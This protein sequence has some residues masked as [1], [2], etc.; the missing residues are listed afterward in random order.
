MRV[1]FVNPVL[2]KGLGYEPSQSRADLLD[3]AGFDVLRDDGSPWPLE[4]RPVQRAVTQGETTRRRVMGLA[5]DGLTRWV[6]ISAWPLIDPGGGRPL[7]AVATYSDVTEGQR[8]R[9]ALVESEAHFRLLA[10]NSTDVITRHLADGTCLYAS[11]AVRD[12]LDRDPSELEGRPA[13]E[14]VHPE[15]RARLFDVFVRLLRSGES[16]TM[17]YRLAHRDGSWVWAETVMRPVRAEGRVLE[18]QSSTR[19]VS[20]RVESENRLARLALGDALTGLANRAAL[21]QHLEDLLATSAPVAL[22][23]LDLDRFKVVN[24]SLGHSAGDELLRT[25]AGRLAGTCRDG[26]VVARLGGDEFV[27]VA[28]GLSQEGAVRLADRVQRVLAAPVQVG[29]HELVVSA[30]V[31][32]VVSGGEI[33]DERAAEDLLRDADVAMYR[34]KAKGRARAVVW[35]EG[36]G[37]APVERLTVEQELR[38]ALEAGQIIVHYQPQVELASGRIVGVEA[39]A[40]WAH[41]TRGLLSPGAFLDVADDTGLVVE[42]GRQVLHHAAQQ[43]VAWRALPGFA[44]LSLSVNLS[45]RELL[46]P[47]QLEV[48]L[49]VL[50]ACGLP[51]NALTLE[52]LESV[53][54]DAEGDVVA[55]LTAYVDH[56]VRLAL[57]DFGTGSSSLLHLRRVPVTAVKIDRSFVL[58]LGHSRQDEAIV[59]ALFSLTS[60]LGMACVAEGVEEPAQREWLIAQGVTVAQGYLLHR[61]LA[62]AALEAVLRA[63]GPSTA[64]G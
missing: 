8:T 13:A 52:V 55:A 40:R 42:L 19:D 31:G 12:V 60:D 46:D 27:V 9:Q 20:S 29:G 1:L 34:A 43:V 45:T 30:S 21:L 23:F 24:D 2:A 64:R 61:P 26:D 17:R 4:E 33:S 16:A 58:G 49:D 62:A 63:D 7:G 51:R 28:A 35:S 54:L 38:V 50:E 59:R 44:A 56:G 18:M 39:L 41:P 15:D 22:L 11:P 3:R 36:T 32:I 6:R 14:F 53:L 48:S 57:D 47:N 5:K 25:V 37:E 10:E